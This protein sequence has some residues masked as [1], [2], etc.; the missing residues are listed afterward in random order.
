VTV[1]IKNLSFKINPGEHV[2]FVGPT[3]SGKTTIIRLLCRLYEP[4]SGQILIDDID[5]KDIPI[6]T[7]RNMLG[8]VLQDTFIFSGNVADNLKLNSNIENLEEPIVILRADTS[9]KHGLIINLLDE[10][11]KIENLKIGIST[12]KQ[13]SGL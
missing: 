13:L 2:A 3:G 9:V 11:R 12:E 4:Q 7:L 8:V 6:A 10:L 1:F 5:I